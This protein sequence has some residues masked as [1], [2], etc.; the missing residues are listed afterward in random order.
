VLSGGD[1]RINALHIADLHMNAKDLKRIQKVREAFF[2]DV[3]K[4]LLE[5]N[6]SLDLVLFT[7]DLIKKGENSNNEYDLALSEFIIPLLEKYKLTESDF[8]YVAGNHEVDRKFINKTYEKGL[9]VQINNT[10][11]LYEFLSDVGNKED[12]LEYKMLSQKLAAFVNFKNVLKNYNRTKATYFYDTYIIDKNNLKI[13][14]VALNSAWRSSDHRDDQGMIVI[15]SEILEEAS[16]DIS[17]CDIKIVLSHHGYEMFAEWDKQHLQRVMAK[18]FNLFC[19]GHIHDSNFN[20]IQSV[21]GSLYISTCASMYSGRIKNGYSLLSLDLMESSLNVY[22]RKW[23]D[24]RGEF[25]QETE[26]CESGIVKCTNFICTSPETNKL[27]DISRIRSELKIESGNSEKVIVPLTNIDSVKLSEIF[28]EPVITNKSRYDKSEPKL[29]TFKLADLLSKHE[30]ILFFGGKEFGKT[31]LLNYIKDQVLSNDGV[32]ASQLPIFINF[33]EI[34]KRN[35]LSIAVVASKAIDSIVTRSEMEKYL[36]EGNIIFLIDDYDDID[37]VAR[38]K[39]KSVLAEIYKLYPTCRYIITVADRISQAFKQES[40]SLYETLG[41]INYYI[42]PMNTTKIRE[43][44][45]KWNI[46]GKFDV[47]K[48][49]KQ[50]VYYFRQ[51]QVP[52][53]PMTVTLFIGVLFRDKSQKNIRNEA[54]LIENYFEEILEKLSDEETDHELDFK[55]KESFLIHMAK[56]MV[57]ND[58]YEWSIDK[59]EEEKLLYFRKFDEDMPRESTFTPFF[60]KQILVNNNRKITFKFRFWLNFFIARGMQKDKD[61]DLTLMSRDDYLKF[62]TAI[63]YKAGLLRDD[64]T[65]L[66]EIDK[67]TSSAMNEIL[68]QKSGML[69]EINQFQ[70]SIVMLTEQVKS[71]IKEKNHVEIKDV[72]SDQMY[73]QNVEQLDSSSISKDADDELEKA[74]RLITLESDILRNTRELSA[75]DRK[76]YISKNVDYYIATM[77]ASIEDFKLFIHEISIKE[78]YEILLGEELD[79]LNNERTEDLVKKTQEIIYRVLPVS[80]ILHMSDHLGNAKL[81][82]TVKELAQSEAEPLKKC[83]LSMLLMKLDFASSRDIVKQLI[84][85]SKSSVIDYIVFTYIRIYCYENKLSTE[86]LDQTIALLEQIRGK[87]AV[88]HSTIPNIA[89]DT[90]ASDVRKEITLKR[91]KEAVKD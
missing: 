32:F 28:V 39:R 89:R 18:N 9:D 19:N 75:D 37:D 62:S 68:G 59:F 55:E 12:N 85:D 49:L 78:I 25:D 81:K 72:A 65:L 48:M 4:L 42:Q 3:D 22:L 84:I 27:I 67:R 51:L 36:I 52:V 33:R 2:N 57:E 15:G 88:A 20:Y 11:A 44:L 66:A 40:I 63:S 26:K 38:E 47:D 29:E 21:L 56:T 76:L 16:K 14:I 70:T 61:F 91:L 74:I 24:L 10:D 35:P 34:P 43:L 73:L 7:G 6:M 31:T 54:Y 60:A 90:F 86:T 45:N 69:H 8:I 5:N 83:F 58:A 50:I 53:T 30:N 1:M 82:N 79:S 64:H 77:W 46:F 23:Y 13:G 41:A 80:V 71:E 17:T 87:Y